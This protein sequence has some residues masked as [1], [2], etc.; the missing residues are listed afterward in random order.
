MSEP[1]WL[2]ANY[3]ERHHARRPGS[4]TLTLCGR[5]SDRQE[6][7][8]GTDPIAPP[9]KACL[10]A[11]VELAGKIPTFASIKGKRW[12]ED[13]NLDIT[14]R[15]KMRGYTGPLFAE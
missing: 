2:K 3:S 6:L 10:Y 8:E 4:T 12:P 1:R 14:P 13:F 11:W 7:P 5:V 9:C 15:K